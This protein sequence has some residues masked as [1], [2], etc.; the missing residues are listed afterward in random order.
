MLIIC[1]VKEKLFPL[2]LGFMSILC[3]DNKKSILVPSTLSFPFS[4]W[5][6]VYPL[7]PFFNLTQK[8]RSVQLANTLK[9]ISVYRIIYLTH[10]FD[11]K[12]K[13]AFIQM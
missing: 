8:V 11:R 10:Y 5:F 9:L 2:C 3:F 1:T 12:I 7:F 6:I 4:T 13:K